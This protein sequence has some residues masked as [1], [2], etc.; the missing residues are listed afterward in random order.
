MERAVA[1]DPEFAMAFRSIGIAYGNMGYA[2][3]RKKYF[4][5]ALEL[6]DRVSDRERLIIQGQFFS[7]SE[8]TYD[9]AIE[10]LNK[11]IE[12]YPEDLLG[13]ITLGFLYFNLEEWDK[14][15]ERLEVPIQNKVEA[16][17]LYQRKSYAYMA[18]GMYDRAKEVLEYYLNEFSDNTFIH[19]S[20]AYNYLYQGKYDSALIEADKAIFLNP[21]LPDNLT[22]KGDIYH[23]RG[24]LIKAEDEYQKLLSAKEPTVRDDGRRRLEALY[25]SQRKFEESK[26]QLKQGMKLAEEV[27]QMGWKRRYHLRFAYIYLRSGILEKAL[28]ECNKAWSSAVETESLGGQ[29]NALFFKG[30]TYVEMNSIDEAQRVADELKEMIEKGM[31][32]KR[33]RYY[34]HLMGMIE[35]ERNN[36]SK[37][38]EDFKKAISLLPFQRSM[39][40][41]HALFMDSL[42]SAFYLSGDG[43]NA[44]EEYEKITALTSGRFSFGDIY[45]KSFYM[46]GR[47]YEDKGWEG[48]AIEHYE[49]FLELWKNADPGI[50]EV[51]DAKKRLAGL[52]S[53]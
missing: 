14:A 10:A 33:M 2:D 3:E 7:I 43:E 26:N 16:Y 4:R 40:G 42:A 5:K 28:K 11:L 15:L 49:K 20:L 30:L 6:S 32:R 46:L 53:H 23:C 29:W 35:L 48:K 45:A 1:I 34:Y 25:L 17:Y 18:K 21:A 37:A 36:F 13:N 52:K 9:K 27:G 8:T 31:N 19:R 22:I 47:I 41:F 12:L 44:R 50:A 39:G 24:D 51:E 38:I